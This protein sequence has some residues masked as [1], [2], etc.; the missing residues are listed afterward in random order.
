MIKVPIEFYNEWKEKT[1]NM[2][3]ENTSENDFIDWIA[4]QIEK[5][6][7]NI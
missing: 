2:G 6:W 3:V 1:S 5:I 7:Y 4:E